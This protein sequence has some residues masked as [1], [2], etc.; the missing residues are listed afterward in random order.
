MERERIWGRR[1]R[2]AG[3]GRGRAPET[4]TFH[5][6]RDVTGPRHSV[7]RLSPSE[8][9]AD[10]ARGPF[11]TVVVPNAGIGVQRAGAQDDARSSGNRILTESI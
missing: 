1:G 9:H 4:T 8:A 7:A 11:R 2:A 6:C 3:K 5:E 10:A